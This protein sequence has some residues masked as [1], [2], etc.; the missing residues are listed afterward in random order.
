MEISDFRE[1][2]REWRARMRGL[3]L[4]TEADFDA[5]QAIEHLREL[6]DKYLVLAG[7][8][9]P[10]G[11]LLNRY[12]AT[13]LTGL[14]AVASSKYDEGTF[15]PRVSEVTGIEMVQT[16]QKEF[17]EAF[18]HGLTLLGLSR[19]DTPLRNLGEILMHA[20]IPISG[21][22]DFL[23]LLQR[24]DSLTY[25]LT[26]TDFCAWAA[27]MSRGV[28]A[29]KGLDAPTWRFL[30]QAGEVATELVDRFLGILD[31]L[32]SGV[33]ASEVSLDALPAHIAAEVGRLLVAGEVSAGRQRRRREQRF[34][35]RLV[36]IDGEIQVHLP[37]FEHRWK[38]GVT[39]Q[40][41]VAGES[42][43][44]VVSAPLPGDS[45]EP[46][47]EVIRRPERNAL[48]AIEGGEQQWDL[49]VVDA[50]SPA[51]V[52]DAASRAALP[53]SHQL[54]KGRAWIAVP[55]ESDLDLAA[56]LD[57]EGTLVV[58]DVVDAPYGW[59]NWAF[60][61]VDLTDVVRLRPRG[62][63]SEFRWRYV[64]SITRP[65]LENVE[66]LPFVRSAAGG[67][68]FAER[69]SVCLPATPQDP[70]GRLA[71]TEWNIAVRGAGA[72]ETYSVVVN[73]GDEPMTFDAWPDFW[74]E[75]IVGEFEIR[76]QG[77][78]GRGA[79][80]MI[81]IAE[82]YASAATP[83]FRWLAPGGGL[84]PCE[85][86][87][88]G[89]DREHIVHLASSDRSVGVELVGEA[90][91][92]TLAV[93]TDVDHMWV[94]AVSSEGASAPGIGAV[95]IE[96][97]SVATSMLRLNTQ[98]RQGGIV[99]LEAGRTSIQ[100]ADLRA[101]QT[102]IATLNLATFADTAAQRGV[103][104]LVYDAVGRT[105][106]LARIRPKALVSE[107]VID[108][109]HL[110]V[111]KNGESLDL[112]LGIYLDFAPWRTPELVHVPAEV[113]LIP[114][115]E[116][117]RGRGPAR[118][119]V[120]VRDPWSFD[121]WPARLGDPGD[122]VHRLDIPAA[123][124]DGGME[125]SFIGW[126]AD[127]APCP[128]SPEAVDYAVDIYG[129]LR[130]A[131]AVRPRRALLA[132]V[133]QL[134]RRYGERF[135]GAARAARWSR[136]THTRL[137]VDGW[138]ATARTMDRA[139]DTRTWRISP[140]LGLLESL[141]AW[142]GTNPELADSLDSNLGPSARQILESGTDEFESV[143]AF[144]REAEIMSG[145]PIDQLNALWRVASPIPGL[146]LERDQRAL[147]ARS[148]FDARVDARVR[149]TAL[150]AGAIVGGCRALLGRELGERAVGPLRARSG[151]DGWPLLPCV[152]IS[153]ALVAR[154]AARGSHDA[155]AVYE[156][157]RFAYA[158]LADCAPDFIEQDLV[159]AELW[160]TRWE[161]E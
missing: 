13:V 108:G 127:I 42:W 145:M 140:F 41:T 51:L 18:R 12:C 34:V 115:P 87:L 70:G 72:D 131:R 56:V 89:A 15:W 107:I 3:S 160:M 58:I 7:L 116:P 30:T 60:A 53:S 104:E 91:A 74:G 63:G 92:T 81:A 52:F 154:L 113:N 1:Q 139:L 23:R 159:L 45:V 98:P 124:G 94:S 150:A 54:P 10:R 119:L 26:G 134:T 111:A 155:L 130:A 114:L 25:D 35:P 109:D 88:S 33:D 77:P 37:P 64:S 36:Y 146:L 40:V 156:R 16:Q 143:G 90:R 149:E 6:G 50:E 49:P 125:D 24:R 121:P 133:G 103:S 96:L 148:L 152:S 61:L 44:R 20:G 84:E 144:R 9:K 101:N 57:V 147:H 66:T 39:W 151:G 78:L 161:N 83:E 132:D 59:D 118:M 55:N 112:E 137:V 32:G 2:D 99:R 105:V 106:V 11:P 38:T 123:V 29:S 43:T 5:A 97:D 47:R 122:N 136:A 102:G 21:I 117:L 80:F 135:H 27:A 69:P 141:G 14:T 138:A 28:A 129:L 153:L 95:N 157:N 8:R 158:E 120:R 31:A 19:F 85:L 71:T 142:D 46:T 65:Y 82:G 22:G 68:V 73:V 4:V 67:H 126:V 62:D 17:A 76:A 86:V 48:I 100:T 79:I 93:V 75:S 110:R 128:E